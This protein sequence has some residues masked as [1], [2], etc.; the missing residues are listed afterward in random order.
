MKE[1]IE[2]KFIVLENYGTVNYLECPRCGCE[3]CVDAHDEENLI[4]SWRQMAFIAVCP[5]CGTQEE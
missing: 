4:W 3:F 2:A 1:P 5:L